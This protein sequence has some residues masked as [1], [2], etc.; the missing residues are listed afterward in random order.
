M[1]YDYKADAARQSVLDR[2]KNRSERG[3]MRPRLYEVFEQAGQ[4]PGSPSYQWMISGGLGDF[5]LTKAN[6]ADD[7][8]IKKLIQN[9]EILPTFEEDYFMGQ[10][11]ARKIQ[12]F[13]DVCFGLVDHFKQVIIYELGSPPAGRDRVITPDPAHDAAMNML[14]NKMGWKEKPA[15]TEMRNKTD[16]PIHLKNGQNDLIVHPLLTDEQH[17]KLRERQRSF[18]FGK[19]YTPLPEGP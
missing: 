18:T 17:I 8:A 9:G 1:G 3:I 19:N 11:R 10:V 7:A 4:K 16:T 2:V 12:H 14:Y 5:P 15:Q 6:P 13:D